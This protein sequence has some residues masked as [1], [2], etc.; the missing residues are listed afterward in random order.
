VIWILVIL[1]IVSAV[2]WWYGVYLGSN[3]FTAAQVSFQPLLNNFNSYPYILW[4]SDNRRYLESQL[5]C[6]P[7]RYRIL[8]SDGHIFFDN[9]PGQPSPPLYTTFE[10]I[11]A[12][13]MGQGEILRDGILNLA[14][15][16]SYGSVE[17]VVHISAPNYVD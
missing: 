2:W 1:I 11:Q 9:R 10:Y 7:Y 6:N 12:V 13:S 15:K 4:F 16:V 17:R 14:V 8:T 5:G 3:R